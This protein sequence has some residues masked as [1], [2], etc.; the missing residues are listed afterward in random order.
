MNSIL[1]YLAALFILILL[2][3]LMKKRKEKTEAENLPQIVKKVDVYELRKGWH[4]KEAKHIYRLYSG[5]LLTWA[6]GSESMQDIYGPEDNLRH[7]REGWE[8]LGGGNL[9][10]ARKIAKHY[11]IPVPTEVTE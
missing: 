1:L 2:A 9:A 5:Q 11:R 6:D 4:I 3:L 7:N 8:F 10:W